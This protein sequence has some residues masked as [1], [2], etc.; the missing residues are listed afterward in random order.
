[1]NFILKIQKGII[2]FSFML[3]VSS[4]SWGQ[5]ASLNKMYQAVRDA[6]QVSFKFRSF[7][8]ME[9]G[10]TEKVM[11]VS[12]T[13]RPLDVEINMLS[14]N[15]GTKVLYNANKRSAYAT[16]Y[17]NLGIGSVPKDF[18]IHGS[19]IMA[20]THHP[21]TATG[22]TPI[23]NLV[24]SASKKAKNEG[25][26]NQVF[27]DRGNVSLDGRSVHKIEIKD[28]QYSFTQYTAKSGESVNAIASKMNISAYK[29]MKINP[30]LSK[31][32][33][34]IEGQNIKIPTSYAKYTCLYIDTQTNL[35]YMAEVHDEKGLFE[36]YYFLDVKL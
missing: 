35:P 5:E 27:F 18:F 30:Q 4:Q 25:R 19:T 26:F 2:L 12:M 24:K 23:V 31:S 9:K 36:K 21:I 1:M 16:V 34:S 8:R 13:H 10:M 22:F 15:K 7:E 3:L 14:P 29:I 32:Y 6:N 28:D 20:D 11:N 33:K 17:I